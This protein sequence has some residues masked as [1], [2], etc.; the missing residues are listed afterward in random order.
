MDVWKQKEIK[1]MEIGGNKNAKDFYEKNGMMG[2]D[3]VPNHKAPALAKYKADLNRRAEAA[4]GM[5]PQVFSQPAA[6]STVQPAFPPPTASTQN[7]PFGAPAQPKQ[8]LLA[9]IPDSKPLTQQ[10]SQP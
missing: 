10:K 2:S 1:C 4:I 5:E 7:D 6:Q 8:D 9:H 3:G